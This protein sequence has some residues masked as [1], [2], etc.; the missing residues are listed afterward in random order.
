MNIKKAVGVGAL[1]SVLS[2]SMNCARDTRPATQDVSIG[3]LTRTQGSALAASLLELYRRERSFAVSTGVEEQEYPG[4]V[5]AGT[6]VGGQARM[7]FNRNYPISDVSSLVIWA[8]ENTKS[9]LAPSD[10]VQRMISIYF[11]TNG[12]LLRVEEKV[13]TGGQL[14]P[15]GVIHED[16]QYWELE[17]A[18]EKEGI[19]TEAGT[20]AGRIRVFIPDARIP[21]PYRSLV[22]LVS[23]DV[24]NYRA[25]R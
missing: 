13:F 19:H 22:D 16:A 4:G 18:N 2:L 20:P 10:T 21:P 15:L 24:K 9:K 17:T 7:I 1:A 6:Y 14:L 23:A 3:V 11:E 12:Q 5:V 25:H 8:Y